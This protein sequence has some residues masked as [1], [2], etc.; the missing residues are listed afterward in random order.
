MRGGERNVRQGVNDVDP[1]IVTVDTFPYAWLRKRV[2][3]QK[4][5]P[6]N[7]R[8]RQKYQYKNIVTAFDI[9]TTRLP[10]IEQGIMYVWQWCFG[11]TCVV[12]G[13]TWEEFLDFIE[14]L[15][16]ALK[17]DERIFCAVHNLS[18][19]FHYL[20][21]IWRFEPQDVFALKPRKI[22]KA[23]LDKIEF[24]CSYL[25][26]NMSLEEY[27]KKMQVEHVKQSGSAFGYEK[28]R[29]PWTELT[30]SE[31]RYATYD[32][33]GLVEAIT[34]E[35]EL[36]GDNLYTFPM[37]S[38][39]YV[40][41]DAKKAMREVS[42]TFVHSQYP[43]FDIFTMLREAFRGGDTHANR[44]FE[45]QIV[46]N[47]YSA[48]RSSSYPEIVC[49]FKFPVSA[50]FHVKTPMNYKDVLDLIL[51]KEKAV[52]MRVQ[53]FNVF[54]T[55]PQNPAP[56]LSR[57]KC[58]NIL[59]GQYDNGRILS[60][61][62]LETTITDVDFRILIKEYTAEWVFT[63]IAYARYGYL[64]KPLIALTCEYYKR[65]TELK[66]DKEQAVY[67]MK[68]KNKLNSIYGMMA[69][70]PLKRS[71]IYTQDGQ[72]DETGELDY[73][74]EDMSKT[75]EDILT[76]NE[77]K[78]FLVYQWGCW[79]TAWARYMLR[80]G[81]W[82]VLEQGAEPLYW[83]T[84]S[85]KYIGAVDWTAYNAERIKA[86]KA[87]GAFAKDSKG[88][89]HYMGV[90]EQEDN[91]ISFCTMGAK[92]YVYTLYNDDTGEVE[93]HCTI[94]GVG[95]TAG[96]KE[97]DAA[98]GIAAFKEG[99]VF[100]DAGGLEAVYNDNPAITEYEIEGHTIKITP[101]VVLRPSTYTLGLSADYARL[102]HYYEYFLEF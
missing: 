27:T 34:K 47:G 14:R 7:P 63:E 80:C 92:K 28:L 48:D 77:R 88:E 38:T 64:P 3:I 101:N 76:D 81:I 44:F 61:D 42:Y 54:L 50:F 11:D 58:R 36:D 13:R 49:N 40:R 35:M 25:H 18:Y 20:R 37:T 94:A 52:I 97:L 73:Y 59:N 53:L 67:Y 57:D 12:V 56:Y 90:F 51:V 16:Y 8:T 45:G 62:F 19:E 41:R 32:V 68:L 74:H 79:V 71:I 55:D 29:F 85:V 43:D 39:G 46:N 70:N 95:K 86:S 30:E 84:D 23:Q 22:L 87:S 65:K 93:T 72:I 102:L 6:G 26:S 60:A 100:H 24:R 9:E 17:P 78:V 5:G 2:P 15:H 96:A 66:G 83:D 75:D 89:I 91:F 82:T 99:F 33:I 10:D 69:Q 4:R 98:G 21:G 1:P 31:M